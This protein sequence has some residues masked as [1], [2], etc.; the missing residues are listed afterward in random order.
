MLLSHCD[1]LHHI[2]RACNCAA[3]TTAAFYCVH[4]VHAFGHATNDSVLTVQECTFIKHDEEL[5]VGR[6][7]VLATRHTNDT[8]LETDVRELGFDVTVCRTAG[9]SATQVT[10]DFAI[11]DIAGLRHEAFDDTVEYHAIVRAVRGDFGDLFDM[12]R[13]HILEQVDR[14]GAFAFDVDLEARRE[15]R[16][17]ENA[18]QN[19]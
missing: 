12:Q 2:W 1:C 3:L 10:T 9:A 5:A 14:N 18:E 8:A 16:C 4:N 19:R 11:F 15:R 6:V 7:R 17:R 13:G